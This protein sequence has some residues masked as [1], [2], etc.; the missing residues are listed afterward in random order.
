MGEPT[1]RYRAKQLR[2]TETYSSKSSTLQVVRCG[3]DNSVRSVAILRQ[4]LGA[5][6]YGRGENLRL[7]QVVGDALATAQVHLGSPG[8][9]HGGFVKRAREWQPARM[10]FLRGWAA[11]VNFGC[12]ESPMLPEASS[13]T[14]PPSST[15]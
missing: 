11:P 13:E 2:A 1:A 10:S 4:R 3:Q 9:A 12:G 15:T 5:A 6:L 7:E 14:T 8:S